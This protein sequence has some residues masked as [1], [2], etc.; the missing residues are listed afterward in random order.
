MKELLWGLL[1]VFI[2]ILSGVITG[3]ILYKFIFPIKNIFK[4]DLLS[5]IIALAIY[6][7]ILFVL[8]MLF[9]SW[10]DIKDK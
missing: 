6:G 10:L 8:L 7:L 3:I 9:R 2:H 4:N 5:F 1:A